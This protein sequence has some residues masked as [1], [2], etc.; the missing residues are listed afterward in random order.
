MHG[1]NQEGQR[2]SSSCLIAVLASGGGGCGHV[3]EHDHVVV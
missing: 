3:E 2:R 1:D